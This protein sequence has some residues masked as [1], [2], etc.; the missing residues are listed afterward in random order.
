[1]SAVLSIHEGGNRPALATPADA[2]REALRRDPDDRVARINLIELLYQKGDE[3]EFLREAALFR[4]GLN[5]NLDTPDWKQVQ[6]I[7]LRLFPASPV[8]AVPPAGERKR[9]L[10]EEP[11]ARAQF[12]ILAR[13]Y[14]SLRGDARFVNDVDREL[15]F[16]AR[17]PTPLAHARQLSAHLK[18]A[19]IFFK[20]EDLAP[21]GGALHVA[22]VGQALLAQ[23]LGKTTLVT[24]TIYGQRGVLVAETAAR[25]GLKAV[26]FMDQRQMARERA[27]VFRMW[28]TGA[29]V[30]AVDSSGLRNHD[31]REAALEHW[32]TDTAGCLPVLGLD[33]GPEPYPTMARQFAGVVGREVRRQMLTFSH[34]APDLVVARGGNHADAIGVFEPFLPDARVRLACIAGRT[35][36]PPMAGLSAPA[37]PALSPSQQRLSGA[38]LEETP[39]PNVTREHA[40]LK[41][42]GRIEYPRMDDESV[43]ET[44]SLVARLEGLVPAIET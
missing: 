27:S 13:Q 33:H 42:T 39:Y 10:G 32:L 14:E 24:G 17:R 1:M 22:V 19:Q 34:R 29:E 21:A 25:L 37:E 38:L 44:I 30:R 28:L 6:A 18:G 8:F 16:V 4:N 41:E 11:K 43:A 20:R 9:R 40:W 36:L 2:L 31:I 35:E 3:H 5:G 12:E 23:R 7:G 26:I 15:L